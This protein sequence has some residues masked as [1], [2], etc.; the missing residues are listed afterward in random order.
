MLSDW[1]PQCAA[2]RA[3]ATAHGFV[4]SRPGIARPALLFLVTAIFIAV[5]VLDADFYAVP[6]WGFIDVTPVVPVS[7]RVVPV[8]IAVLSVSS[9]IHVAITT[10][11]AVAMHS[12]VWPRLAVIA[13]HA[14]AVATMHPRVVPHLTVIG[15]RLVTIDPLIRPLRRFLVGLGRSCGLRSFGWSLS[16]PLGE[17]GVETGRGE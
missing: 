15:L 17:R 8:S 5:F 16:T 13:A 2:K 11:L 9:T 4:N 6:R 14:V 3:S 10:H 12:P 7:V 1:N